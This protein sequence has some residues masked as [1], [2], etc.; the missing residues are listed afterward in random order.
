MLTFFTTH[1]VPSFDPPTSTRTV[2]VPL[3]SGHP[4][5]GKTENMNRQRTDT[6]IPDETLC[7]WITPSRKY[8]SL[9]KCH[10]TETSREPP[11]RDPPETIDTLVSDPRVLFSPQ[12]ESERDVVNL[13]NLFRKLIL[14][15]DSQ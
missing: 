3:D 10:V 13:I 9:G 1:F 4:V 6:G 11:T 15:V 7:L 14:H 8:P 12:E 2:Q 5:T